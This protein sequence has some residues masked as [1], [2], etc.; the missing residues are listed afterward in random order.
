[1]RRVMRQIL[2]VGIRVV[3]FLQQSLTDLFKELFFGCGYVAHCLSR[4]QKAKRPKLIILPAL[5]F[6]LS[7]NYYSF[8]ALASFS[9][10]L[11]SNVPELSPTPSCTK[12]CAAGS[13]FDSSEPFTNSS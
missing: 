6:S 2:Q 4:K 3:P 7:A 13:W 10:G 9:S 1:M 8:S 11:R 12:A 5:V